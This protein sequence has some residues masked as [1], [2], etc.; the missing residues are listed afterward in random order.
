VVDLSKINIF[1]DKM[2]TCKMKKFVYFKY[3]Q[4]ADD[5]NSGR[6]MVFKSN[7]YALWLDDYDEIV[8]DYL[9]TLP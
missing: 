2:V 6:F 4:A 9:M 5:A 3:H 1:G 7:P 8:D